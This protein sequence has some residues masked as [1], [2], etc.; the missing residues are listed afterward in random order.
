MRQS[1]SILEIPREEHRT[2]SKLLEL[3][4]SAVSV[5]APF[6]HFVHD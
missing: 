3:R 5:A 4:A 6:Q 2:S 1:N